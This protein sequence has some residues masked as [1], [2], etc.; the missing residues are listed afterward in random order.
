MNV[1]TNSS[2]PDLEYEEFGGLR[3]EERKFGK[4]EC[5]E[6]ILSEMEEKKIAKPWRRIRKLK[7]D[8]N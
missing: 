4:Y 7:M 8:E 2:E 5:P 1:G 3:I 6:F